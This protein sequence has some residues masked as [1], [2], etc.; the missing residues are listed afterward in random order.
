MSNF[1]AALV[2]VAALLLYTQSAKPEE[3]ME[4]LKKELVFY[5]DEEIVEIYL[6]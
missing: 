1:V 5:S 3:A 4:Y 2:L 6:K